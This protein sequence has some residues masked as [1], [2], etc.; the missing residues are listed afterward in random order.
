MVVN[1]KILLKA[2]LVGT[3]L[4]VVMAVISS[5]VVMD[6]TSSQA[7]LVLMNSGETSV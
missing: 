1:Q 5:T 3:S 7:A 2:G 6:A 4:M